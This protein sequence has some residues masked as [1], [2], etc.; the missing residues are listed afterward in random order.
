MNY[1]GQTGFAEM[2]EYY[3]KRNVTN[4]REYNERAMLRWVDQQLQQAQT[5]LSRYKQG[6][7]VDTVTCVSH[8]KNQ[9]K[10]TQ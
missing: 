1:T 3:L 8:P 5:E 10:T 6:V 4:E 2:F 9:S 7:E